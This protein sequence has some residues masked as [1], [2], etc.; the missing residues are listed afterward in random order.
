M[1]RILLIILLCVSSIFPQTET[2][3]NIDIIELTKAGLSQKVILEKIKSSSCEF[4]SSAKALIE[5]K[6]S[7]VDDE[8]ISEI[9]EKSKR[10]RERIIQSEEKPQEFVNYSENSPSPE[11]TTKKTSLQIL[12]SAKTIAIKKSSLHPARQTLEKALLKRED[13]RK[14]NLTLTEFPENADLYIDIGRVPLT[15]VTHRYVFRIF[16]TRSGVVIAAGE[17]TSWGSLADNLARNIIKSLKTLEK[18]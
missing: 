12:Q 5:L 2:L 13:W 14:Y 8:V 11:S 16:D 4:D 9:I 1:K 15:L 3:T 18:E 6:K 10:Q 17:T 7:G